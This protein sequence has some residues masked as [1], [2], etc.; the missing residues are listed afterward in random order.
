M[1]S[2]PLLAAHLESFILW[3]LEE[4]EGLNRD[5]VI[6]DDSLSQSSTYIDFIHFVINNLAVVDKTGMFSELIRNGR[7]VYLRPRRFGKSM[8]LSTLKYFFFG[9]T[10]LF[11]KT[12]VFNH[13]LRFNTFNWCPSNESV[14]NFPPCPVLHLDMSA[15]TCKTAKSF[16]E[17]VIS[18]L[19]K[20]AVEYCISLDDFHEN[21][22]PALFRHLIQKLCDS[23]WNN[24]KQVVILVDEYDSVLNQ[25]SFDTSTSSLDEKSAITSV[26]RGLFS[27]IKSYDQKILFAYATGIT[28]FGMAGLYS[29]ANNFVNL[30]HDPF[31]HSLCG[32]TKSEVNSLLGK[33]KSTEELRVLKE[34]YN[35]YSFILDQKYSA[36]PRLFNPYAI[37]RSIKDELPPEQFWSATN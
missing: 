37:Y 29:G 17:L 5:L 33:S 26:L 6:P 19:K 12:E 16:E 2:Y 3:S 31:L 14:H 18:R 15:L 35:G 22:L 13:L 4:N 36:T 10:N 11:R 23:Q 30:S 21:G 24:W 25:L 8:L 28:W 34:Y 1:K 20:I 27:E 32:F 9:A 7:V